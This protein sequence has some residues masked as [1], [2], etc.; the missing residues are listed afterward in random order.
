MIRVLLRRCWIL[1]GLFHLVFFFFLY[2]FSNVCVILFCSHLFFPLFFSLPLFFFFLSLCLSLSLFSLSLSLSLLFFYY[3]LLFFLSWHNILFCFFRLLSSV[4][5]WL[6]I[7]Y[8]IPSFLLYNTFLPYFLPPSCIPNV[9]F[10]FFFF[11]YISQQQRNEVICVMQT[12][13]FNPYLL[14]FLFL[15]QF[16][17]HFSLLCNFFQ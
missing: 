4:S 3:S 2:I 16:C 5:Y 13:T 14:I 7:L 15:L 10:F 9:F 1:V 11:T 17:S 12:L 8:V 6:Y